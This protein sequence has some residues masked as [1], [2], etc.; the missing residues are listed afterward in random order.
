MSGYQR[1]FAIALGRLRSS[2]TELPRELVFEVERRCTFVR[3]LG[4]AAG[5]APGEGMLR[6]EIQRRKINGG[7]GSISQ[8]GKWR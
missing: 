8:M 1:Q 5:V 6:M 4:A 2:K 3:T 7:K